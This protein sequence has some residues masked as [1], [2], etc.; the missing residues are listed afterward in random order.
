[1]VF[2]AAFSGDSFH[3]LAKAA[4]TR[5]TP[6]TQKQ[7]SFGSTGDLNPW[8]SFRWWSMYFQRKQLW[9]KG[10]KKDFDAVCWP[11]NLIFGLFKISNLAKII[12]ITTKSKKFCTQRPSRGKAICHF[13]FEYIELQ[14]AMQKALK[15]K[16]DCEQEKLESQK[17]SQFLLESLQTLDTK[18]LTPTPCKA[19]PLDPER[20]GLWW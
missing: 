12:G 15:F 14:M 6:Q 20:H 7:K 2:E 17:H 13:I 1:M 10:A 18:S 3:F 8:R 19:P 4:C 11:K 9:G 5:S 16:R